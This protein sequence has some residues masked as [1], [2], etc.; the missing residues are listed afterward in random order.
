L[1]TYSDFSLS[2]A[3]LAFYVGALNLH[4][5]LV[6][7]GLMICWPEPVDDERPRLTIRDLRDVGMLLTHPGPVVGNDIDAD[8]KWLIVI[9][10]ANQGGKSTFLRSVGL[11]QLMMQAGLFVTAREFC[12]TVA[13]GIYT[14]FKRE[15]DADMQSGKF[16]EELSRLSQIIDYLR[17]GSMLCLN[18][19]FA[20][21]DE[22]EGSE[23][24]SEI[25]RA[26]LES[27]VR[28]L[29]V[30]HLHALAQKWYEAGRSD[31]LFL[32]A[33]RLADGSRSFKVVEGSPLE[34]S[35]G[36]DLYREIFAPASAT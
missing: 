36:V 20:S 11:A 27:R 17:P 16:D 5:D 10:G 30:T 14:H 9:T 15:E 13:R 4:D 1:I 25:V 19:S 12:A 26:L 21:T 8:N 28:I 35:F 24:S 23:V 33:E 7:L 32:R 22:R 31:T 6:H 3:E 34:T 18:E 29:F 2:C